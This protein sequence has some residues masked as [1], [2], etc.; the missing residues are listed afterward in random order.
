M[1]DE[2]L[3]SLL[4]VIIVVDV[5]GAIAYFVLGTLKRRKRQDLESGLEPEKPALRA[6]PGR[7][8]ALA[9][10]RWIPPWLRPGRKG[11]PATEAEY[12]QLRQALSSLTEDLF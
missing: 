8:G 2:F 6:S 4:K 10:A 5:V 3:T 1:F 9:V 12:A 7:R 11:I